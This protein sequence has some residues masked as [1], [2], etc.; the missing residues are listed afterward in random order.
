MNKYIISVQLNHYYLYS[1]P[2]NVQS[3]L[4]AFGI[5]TTLHATTA[6]PKSCTY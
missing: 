5:F 2:L 6:P 4:W 1:G 3:T